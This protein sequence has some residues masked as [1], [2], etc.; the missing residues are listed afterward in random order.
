MNVSPSRQKGVQYMGQ[1]GVGYS[2]ENEKVGQ[3][4][5]SK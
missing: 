1:G 3:R 2:T 4:E 5:N